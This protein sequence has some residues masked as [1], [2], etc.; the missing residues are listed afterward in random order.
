MHAPAPS[1]SQ[2]HRDHVVR[3]LSAAFADDLLSTDQLDQ[4]LAA[5]Y[6]AQ[7]MAE[8]QLQLVDP[9]DPRRWLNDNNRYVTANELV[10]ERGIAAAIAGAFTARGGWL[11]PRHLKVW[12]VAGGGDLDLREA[13]FAPGI[14]EIEVV[15]IMGGVDLILP[16]GIRV[17]V[18]GAAFLGGFEHR[19][20]MAV[21]DPDAPLV[22]VSGLAALGAVDVTRTRR[23]YKSEKQY[24]AALARATEM[25]RGR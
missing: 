17:E 14:T 25:S 9:A 20:G 8:L 21:E 2:G 23:E 13:R 5:V 12:A 18:I 22:R 6:R 16:E 4:R 19:S 11:V 24:L 7:S 1:I 15:S 3:L 10:P